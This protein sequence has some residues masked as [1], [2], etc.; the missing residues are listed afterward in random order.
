MQNLI[1]LGHRTQEGNTITYTAV[2]S[3]HATVD[4]PAE[5]LKVSFDVHPNNK[6]GAELLQAESLTIGIEPE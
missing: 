1:K 5:L 2:P 4:D 3:P 6:A